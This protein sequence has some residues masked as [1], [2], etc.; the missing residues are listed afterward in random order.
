VTDRSIPVE[1]GA[2]PATP[3]PP[4]AAPMIRFVDVSRRWP[5][6]REGLSEVSFDIEAGEMVFVTGHSGAG[7]STVLRLVS[8]ADRATRGKVWVGGRDVAALRPRDLPGFRRAIG[9]VFQDH[10]LLADRSVAAN[11][12]LPLA[13]AG[14]PR[15]EIDKRVRVVL[16]KVGLGDRG[17][18]L[19]EELSAGEQQRVGIAR[20][21]APKPPLLIA[22]EP[23]GNLDPQLAQEIMTL[24]L[25][26]AEV[27][28]TVVIASHDLHLIRRMRRRVLVLERGR[29]IDDFRPAPLR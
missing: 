13:I 2:T 18:A 5:G 6:G 15:A 17:N 8:G 26:L 11:V 12:A 10:R 23:T 19:P 29:L 21:V 14:L 16:D 25:T 27:G 20:A 7:K 3:S 24:F 9:Q 4:D 22:D 28:T 1:A